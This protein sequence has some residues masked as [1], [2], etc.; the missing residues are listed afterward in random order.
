M[1]AILEDE[2]AMCIICHGETHRDD[3]R[4]PACKWCDIEIGGEG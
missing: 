3:M 1:N 4:G 2:Y